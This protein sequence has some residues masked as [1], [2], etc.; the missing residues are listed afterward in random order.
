MPQEQRKHILGW[1]KV[2]LNGVSR[3]W[4]WLNALQFAMTVRLE[5]GA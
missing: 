4:A 5:K 2:G 3:T 1:L